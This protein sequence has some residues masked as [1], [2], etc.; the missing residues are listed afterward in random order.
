MEKVYRKGKVMITPQFVRKGKKEFAMDSI[1]DVYITE[2]FL[3]DLFN[4][5]REPVDV[6]IT[7][8]TLPKPYW[9]VEK[10]EKK[11]TRILKFHLK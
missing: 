3:Y 11:N 9:K 6:Q 10:K 7:V 4:R 1:V 8:S 2:N 5:N